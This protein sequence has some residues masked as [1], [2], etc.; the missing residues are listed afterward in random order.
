M[1][2]MIAAL[3]NKQN[4]L[5]ESPTG[6]GKTLGLLCVGL[7]WQNSVTKSQLQNQRTN[8]LDCISGSMADT[9][10]KVPASDAPPIPIERMAW[11]GDVASRRSV[12]DTGRAA[13]ITLQY[14]EAEDGTMLNDTKESTGM[15]CDTFSGREE[16]CRRTGN[17]I[18]EMVEASSLQ[19]N[20]VKQQSLPKSDIPTIYFC[21]RTHSQLMQAVKELRSCEKFLH[22]VNE[23]E[24]DK[25][26]ECGHNEATTGLPKRMYK[27]FTMVMMMRVC[28]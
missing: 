3:Q 22:I 18:G 23:K 5:I 26:M 27:S 9:M 2:K 19:H 20:E 8:H 7:A 28:V 15:Q 12:S 10:R 1:S 16:Q 6:T 11:K 17:V 24:E 14:E 25:F 21:S 4:A 13:T